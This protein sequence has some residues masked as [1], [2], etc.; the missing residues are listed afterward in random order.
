MKY[1]YS[2]LLGYTQKELEFYFKNYLL[3]VSISNNIHLSID[4]LLIEIKKQYNEYLFTE[5]LYN[6]E[7]I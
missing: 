3:E 2:C 1:N 6:R 7:I 4:N 5:S